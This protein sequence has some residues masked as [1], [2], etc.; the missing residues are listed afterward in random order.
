MPLA[1]LPDL[2][3]NYRIDGAAAGPAVVFT[4]ALGLD[5]T[6]WDAVMPLLPGSLR[7]IRYD[8]RGH[9]GS[10][11]PAPPYTMG[12]LVRDAERLLDHLAV[13]DCVFVGLSIGGLVAQ[14]LAVKRLDQ[15]RALMLSGTAARIGIASQ[16]QDRIAKVQAGGMAAIAE[17]T[18]QR[19][20]SRRFRAAGLDAPWRDLLNRCNPQGYI[21]CAHAIAG[22][23]FYQTTA[24]LTLPTL[25]LAGSEDGS[26]PPDLVRET[27]DLILG[28]R[29]QLLRGVGHL[30]GIEAPE[31]TAAALTGF[32]EAIGHV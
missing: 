5:L 29:F 16:W 2:R 22:S 20:F 4:H 3:L 25:A 31:A 13:R 7:L 23:D 28:S 6:I 21:G 12:A 10:D 19:W 30:P 14:G 1:Y 24:R 9:G 8:L 17:P 32:L 11:V 26:T 27:A 18:M 15:V